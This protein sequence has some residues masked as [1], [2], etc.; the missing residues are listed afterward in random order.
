MQSHDILVQNNGNR[1]SHKKKKYHIIKS[2]ARRET[3]THV[4]YKNNAE[5]IPIPIFEYE[6][7]RGAEIIKDTIID[8]NKNNDDPSFKS[9]SELSINLYV[10]KCNKQDNIY[11]EER[12]LFENNIKI[13]KMLSNLNNIAH[14][15]GN[16]QGFL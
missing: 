14:C 13:N 12:A 9:I 10:N 6:F 16:C 15:P 8:V 11:K 7:T 4:E 5:K 2:T 3:K 1:G